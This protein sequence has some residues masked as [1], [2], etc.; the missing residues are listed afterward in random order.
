MPMKKKH[1][2]VTF[3]VSGPLLEA[4]Q[5]LPNRSE[6]IREAVLAALGGTCPLCLGTGNLTPEQRA[7]WDA[8]ARSH[9]I[10]ECDTCHERRLTC[11]HEPAGAKAGRPRGA[12][13]PR[14]RRSS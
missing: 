2:V 6:F 1:E 7:H 5:D 13:R 14:R 12:R 8:F 4:M 3:K 9:P 10:R 11:L